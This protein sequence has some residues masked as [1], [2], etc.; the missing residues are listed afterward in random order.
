MWFAAQASAAVWTFAT[1]AQCVHHVPAPVS[2]SSRP[3]RRPIQ[4]KTV[5][6]RSVDARGEHLLCE[7]L[8]ELL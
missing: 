7:Y 1:K 2:P 5:P 8:V 4:A 6:L 3:D